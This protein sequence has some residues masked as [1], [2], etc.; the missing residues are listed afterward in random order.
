MPDSGGKGSWPKDV[1]IL[2]ATDLVWNFST[3]TG[4]RDLLEWLEK[5]FNPDYPAKDTKRYRRAYRTLCEVITER[6]GKKVTSLWLFLEFAYKRKIPC[7]AWQ[8]A[9]WNE[10]LSRLGYTV[11]RRSTKDL[12][13][14]ASGE[15]KE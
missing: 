11:P 3:R 10:M 9:C 14:R 6:F 1:P 7:L 2:A 13:L 4:R 12:G 5:T 8:A 15:R